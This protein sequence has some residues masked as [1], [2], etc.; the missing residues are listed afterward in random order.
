M[1]IAMNDS[2]N[3][4]VL[5]VHASGTLTGDDYSKLLPAFEQ[6]IKR[7]NKVNVLFD[8]VD[9]HGW[10][11]KGLWG[12]LKFDLKHFADVGRFAMVG[13]QKWEKNLTDLSRPFTT[14][15]VRY[16]DRSHLDEA[17]AWVAAA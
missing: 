9:F 4:R 13:D 1:P 12:D 7:H 16:F 15:E 11:A 2:N 14:A 17:R 3:G 8:M 5:E 10:D 6:R